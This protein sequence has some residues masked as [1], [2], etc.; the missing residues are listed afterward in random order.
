MIQ[1]RR[2]SLLSMAALFVVG[3]ACV[4]VVYLAEWESWTQEP[5]GGFT[6]TATASNTDIYYF[7]ERDTNLQEEHSITFSS[8]HRF[9]TV[10]RKWYHEILNNPG[11]VRRYDYSIQFL[12]NKI[13]LFAGADLVEMSDFHVLDLATKTWSE[14]SPATALAP[15]ERRS[16]F[17]FTMDGLIYVYGGYAQQTSN[18]KIYD[19]LWSYNP[20]TNRWSTSNYTSPTVPA[21]QFP[22]TAVHN[23]CLYLWGGRITYPS[24]D[25]WRLD[26]DQMNWT[27]VF[28]IPFTVRL[29]TPG[30][31]YKEKLYFFGGSTSS[32]MFTPRG[33][34]SV[35]NLTDPTDR[36]VIDYTRISD[37]YL[38]PSKYPAARISHIFIMV[39]DKMYLSIGRTGTAIN[40]VWILNPDTLQWEWNSLSSYPIGRIT[41]AVAK[42]DEKSFLMFGEGTSSNR[43]P[44]NDLWKFDIGTKSWTCLQRESQCA[45]TNTSCIP[46]LLNPTVAY[47]NNSLYVI[48][49]DI[50]LFTETFEIFRKF[51]LATNTWSSFD[52]TWNTPSTTIGHIFGAAYRIVGDFLYIWGGRTNFNSAFSLSA[53]VK[54]H[55]GTM[56]ASLTTVSGTIPDGRMVPSGFNENGRFC[57]YGGYVTLFN[58]YG[59]VWCFDE[60][61]NGNNTW[62]NLV[63]TSSTNFVNT[64]PGVMY[65]GQL[66]LFGGTLSNL[67]KNSIFALQGQTF[68]ELPKSNNVPTTMG[69]VVA[70]LFGSKMVVI[71][72]QIIRTNV[73]A[74]QS[75]DLSEYF[76]SGTSS[77]DASEVTTLGDGSG[78]FYYFPG[79]VCRWIVSGA[80][81]MSLSD[82]EISPG[83]SI[84]LSSSGCPQYSDLFQETVIHETL[85]VANQD[86]GKA[87]LFS[88]D[89]I[90]VDF[91]VPETSVGARGFSIKAFSCPKGFL[92]VQGECSCPSTRFL[93]VA[94]ECAQC[95]I[96]MVQDPLDAYRC[97]SS[98]G[99][100][101]GS[102]EG[103]DPL[104]STDF[105]RLSLYP[106]PL[107]GASATSI[108]NDTYVVGGYTYDD[109]IPYLFF[110]MDRLHFV[111]GSD[112]SNWY[113]VETSG[114]I[115]PGRTDACLINVGNFLYLMGG[116]SANVTDH[117]FYRLNVKTRVWTKLTSKYP[118]VITGQLCVLDGPVAY[119]YGGTYNNETQTNTVWKFTPS[120]DDLQVIASTNTGPSLSYTSGGFYQ[121]KIYVYAGWDGRIDS[122]KLYT[123][124]LK[125]QTWQLNLQVQLSG[126][127]TECQASGKC[128]FARRHMSYGLI[129][130]ELHIFGGLSGRSP[131]SDSM[132]IDL[133]LQTIT[134]YANYD[135]SNIQIPI[136][137]PSTKYA[138][139]SAV[140]ESRVIT[141]GGSSKDSQMSSDC[142]VWD[143]ELRTWADSSIYYQPIQRRESAMTQISNNTVLIF[144][145]KT[146]FP[147]PLLL[148]D[149]WSFNIDTRKWTVISKAT[150]SS[151]API[152]RS[153]AT[154]IAYN[155][156][157]YVWGGSSQDTVI[158]RSLWRF[159]LVRNVWESFFVPG[160]LPG[161]ERP[162]S[163]Y[164]IVVARE[165]RIAW[166]FGGWVDSTVSGRENYQAL[167]RWDMH[168]NSV[169][170]FSLQNCPTPR[171]GHQMGAY[172]GRVYVL[173]GADDKGQSLADIWSYSASTN[174]WTLHSSVLPAQLLPTAPGASIEHLF[175]FYVGLYTPL[176]PTQTVVVYDYESN[177]F[178]SG[179]VHSTAN[180]YVTSEGRS[181]AGA[182]GNL[183]MFGG[184]S[185]GTYTN[186]LIGHRPSYCPRMSPTIVNGNTTR[187]V[188]DDGSQNA[189]YIGGSYCEWIISDSNRIDIEYSLGVG[190][191]LRVTYGTINGTTMVELTGS[192]NY[193]HA[194]DGI[195]FKIVLESKIQSVRGG[196]GF[197]AGHIKCP[198]VASVID[199]A[200]ECP[201]SSYLDSSAESCIPCSLTDTNP[202]CLKA[203]AEDDGSDSTILTVLVP[204]VV[205]V[206]TFSIF[207]LSIV[208]YLFRKRLSKA[209][210]KE[211]KQLLFCDFNELKFFELIGSGSFGEVYRGS[212][213]G[214]DVAIKKILLMNLKDEVIASF[215]AEIEVMVEL[216]HPNILLY[217]SASVNTATPCI[218]SEFMSQ[219]SL[220]TILHRPEVDLT[221]PKKIG[222]ISGIAQG[223]HYLHSCNPPV[224]HRDLKSPNVLL[225]NKWSV[226]L[227]DFGLSVLQGQKR[228]DE[229]GIGSIPWIAPEV[230]DGQAYTDKADVYSFAITIWE[231]L[232]RQEPYSD[233]ESPLTVAVKVT[234]DKVRP[235]IPANIP[236]ELQSLMGRCWSHDMAMRPDFSEIT[237]LVSVL[238]SSQGS[239]S[240][241]S[242]PTKE[243]SSSEQS[244]SSEGT[245]AVVALA[246][247][248]VDRIWEDIPDA[249]VESIIMFNDL[250]H[251]INSQFR[252]I[253]TR[254]DGH[255][256]MILFEDAIKALKFCIMLQEKLN[257][258]DWSDT[259]LAH[260]AAKP[261]Y[262]GLFKGLRVKMGVSRGFC[263]VVNTSQVQRPVYSGE[264]TKIARN[265][266]RTALGGQILMSGV[267]YESIEKKTSKIQA[268]LRLIG[269]KE[270]SDSKSNQVYEVVSMVQQGRVDLFQAT[271]SRIQ[272]DNPLIVSSEDG[273][274]K[275][276]PNYIPDKSN[277]TPEKTSSNSEQ[278]MTGSF[279]VLWEDLSM[280]DQLLGSGSYG[281]VFVANYKGLKVAVKKIIQQNDTDAYYLSFASEVRIHQ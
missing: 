25:L 244:K 67:P 196:K 201:T 222:F 223:M 51:D 79:T 252:G 100:Q 123:F 192:G 140:V 86:L 275:D 193:E 82:I 57:F 144:G 81:W 263:K 179:Y 4:G 213:R 274:N 278:R 202:A 91:T 3:F 255:V 104:L 35:M 89:Y 279:E 210:Y 99:N 240:P 199:Q 110:P 42:I 52:I 147:Y 43:Y 166:L 167:F 183:I 77:V 63:S 169:S 254:S 118:G 9:S 65:F 150:R 273:S 152:P 19:D 258:L 128:K 188:F 155:M 246:I 205:S 281:R 225:D 151:N 136:L 14:I 198:M 55:L 124:D 93:N 221:V 180:D 267:M 8:F 61:A 10:D 49:G 97:I 190:D 113:S 105:Q 184:Q 120:S 22:V 262:D 33:D 26:I 50:R 176:S 16:H 76:C 17:T 164:G 103:V 39:G 237:S 101:V 38:F 268:S 12:D 206:G 173:G 219:G 129:G 132:I 276:V 80:Y 203:A 102:T 66:L 178:I 29:S 245:F 54:L 145:G 68:S 211:E 138:A 162:F 186:S 224:W 85:S 234:M 40:D 95:P 83:T 229:E 280:S 126:C 156:S 28:D 194:G 264:T 46:S 174:V 115:P 142:W 171:S 215:Q 256:S 260:P 107:H 37:Y 133:E 23:R 117:H 177:I 153:L 58:A 122:E 257:E 239:S 163:R 114:N 59:D 30:I 220:Y 146:E 27:R 249:M 148:N 72:G 269:S 2:D 15:K 231:V 204:T 111:K 170:S 34:L 119:M 175:I 56:Q 191:K 87:F 247:S 197:V 208:V 149:I 88:T 235:P 135:K 1:Q 137:A 248:D 64:L 18:N 84:Q 36:V 228:I 41:P 74:M 53:P 78:T 106:P 165:D 143:A 70:E 251:K 11:P 48:G 232:T 265:L 121:S 195:E 161:N 189:Y 32:F 271:D 6:N 127:V 214:T 141:I 20:A 112:F 98:V 21:L 216:R 7:G 116:T 226:K 31:I 261:Q 209:V 250:V 139:A 109:N 233:I 92:V 200:C 253:E 131:L 154:I 90:V 130:S 266:C 230:L 94:G 185:G 238:H 108:G 272:R 172:S 242:A 44:L 60:R 277:S 62:V 212:W 69:T 207:M 270:N 182:G 181:S 160:N 71:S 158:D 187:D 157:V 96:G 168:S 236:P 218:I 134:Y 125:T 5:V 259:L 159:D 241:E 243:S 13:Y 45:P 75:I 73:F 47:Y 217:M 24:F 227:C